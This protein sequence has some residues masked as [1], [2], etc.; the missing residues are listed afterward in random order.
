MSA[1]TD[2]RAREEAL[3]DRIHALGRE[4]EEGEEALY[5]LFQKSRQAQEDAYG[6]AEQHGAVTPELAQQFGRHQDLFHGVK[7]EGDRL[8]DRLREE[9]AE[10]QRELAVLRDGG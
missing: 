3:E 8:I 2:K 10:F 4:I 9:Q 5:D 7:N 1:D 6:L